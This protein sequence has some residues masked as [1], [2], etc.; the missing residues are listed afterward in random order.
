MIQNFLH[1]VASKNIKHQNKLG[2]AALISLT[3]FLI[4]SS[5]SWKLPFPPTSLAAVPAGILTTLQCSPQIVL[6]WGFPPVTSQLEKNIASSEQ[7]CFSLCTSYRPYWNFSRSALYHIVTEQISTQWSNKA[8]AL[9]ILILTPR[10]LSSVL[11]R[12]FV[13]FFIKKLFK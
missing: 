13:L 6:L 10:T 9:I 11:Y 5:I 3:N 8:W 1:F 4:T 7:Q 2:N 12:G